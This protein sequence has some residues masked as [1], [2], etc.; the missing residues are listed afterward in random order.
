LQRRFSALIP[1]LVLVCL[2]IIYGSLFPFQFSW[3]LAQNNLPGFLSSW[4]TVNG[5]GDILGNI[6][7]FFPLGMLASLI[8]LRSESPYRTLQFACLCAVLSL[9]CQV[10]QLFTAGRDPSIFDFYVNLLGA[11]SGWLVARL[12]PIQSTGKSDIYQLPLLIASSWIAYQ[13]IPFVP[14]IEIQAYENSLKPLLQSP[15]WLWQECLVATLSWLTFFYLL[16]RKAGITLTLGHLL[17][18]G[19]A[20]L[21]LRI[22]ILENYLDLTAV[23]S[24]LIATAI[25]H[26][27]GAH[28][29]AERLAW[30]LLAAYAIDMTAPWMMFEQ[31]KRFGWLPFEGYLMGSMLL[32][33]TALCRK[34]FIFASIAL[35]LSKGVKSQRT[36]ALLIALGLFLLEFAQRWIGYGTPTLTDPLLFL[37]IFWFTTALIAPA[38]ETRD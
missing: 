7:L 36:L 12:L 17:L 9:G 10:A 25:W 8:T 21:A 4:R 26:F 33:A 6:V 19:F 24:V 18:G 22:V 27:W 3:S 1:A 23:L 13:L 38:E 34:V 2:G 31:P 20:I 30:V 14:A 35:L 5:L 37:T 29:R 32:N 15:R 16:D 11:C 28:F